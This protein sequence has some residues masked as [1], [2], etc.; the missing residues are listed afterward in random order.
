[1]D[2]NGLNVT[3]G[4]EIAQS[5]QSWPQKTG[6]A[7]AFVLDHPVIGYSVALLRVRTSISAAV[8]LAIV[9]S[10]FCCSEETL[11]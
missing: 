7:K 2:Q 3:L 9:F 8:W 5:L 11:A 1:M 6:A 4:S 10:S